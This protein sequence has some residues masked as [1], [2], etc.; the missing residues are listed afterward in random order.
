MVFGF[1]YAGIVEENKDPLKLG[2]VKVRVPHVYG[3]DATGVGYIGVNDLPWAM[4]AGMPAGGSGSSGGFS[5]LP[6]KGDKVWV[7]FLD[8]EPEKPI[9]EWGMQTMD[10][11]DNLRLHRYGIGVPVGAPDRTFWTRYGQAIELNEGAVIATTSQGYRLVLTDASDVGASDGE[12]ALTTQNGN[13]IQ[14]SDLDDTI[15]T[16]VLE[17]LYY[18]VGNGVIGQ[19]DSFS[20]QTMSLDFDLDIG[21]AFNLTT[22]DGID[23]TT[24]SDTFIDSLGDT[25]FTTTGDFTMGFTSLKLGLAAVEPCVLGGQLVTFLTSL[26]VWLSTHTHNSASPGSPTTPPNVPPEPVV[27]PEIL[28]LISATITVQN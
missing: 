21:G 3:S 4:P 16:L 15:K 27:Q 1:T 24:A 17:D 18:T 28:N 12:I 23:I 20:W 10:D 8:G 19:S 2:R 14:M 13:M 5:Q 6:A 7:R 11:R 26:F 22:I 25:T 9:W